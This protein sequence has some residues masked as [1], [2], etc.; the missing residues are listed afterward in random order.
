MIKALGVAFVDMTRDTMYPGQ[1]N[2]DYCPD[3]NKWPVRTKPFWGP[4]FRPTL[5]QCLSCGGV[6][7]DHGDHTPIEE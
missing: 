2:D 6:W 7:Q 4:N 3:C 5:R 1:R